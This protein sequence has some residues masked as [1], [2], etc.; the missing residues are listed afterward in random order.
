MP[1][2]AG[3]PG[4]GQE[5][6]CWLSATE[7]ATWLALGA[8]VTRLPIALD[9]DL[10]AASGLSLFEYLVLS[11]LSEAP[12]QTM[13]MSELGASVNSSPSRLSH[14][15]ARL[16]RHGWVCRAPLP[17]DGRQVTAT[18]T[19][20]GYRKVEASAPRHVR[21]VRKLI[22]DAL[23]PAQLREL[24]TIAGAIL[25]SIDT[26]LGPARTG[27]PRDEPPRGGGR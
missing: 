4:G 24:G 10:Q 23:T 13:R 3:P 5:E 22:I 25:E 6:P 15:I 19:P 26:E 20:Q 9:G 27:H 21:F 12:G 2:A 16:E 11:G 7:R 14:G 18:L 1:A 8:L 17:G